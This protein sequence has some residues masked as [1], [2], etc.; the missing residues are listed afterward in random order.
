[1]TSRGKVLGVVL[2]GAVLLGLASNKD[3]L[4]EKLYTL[5]L[6]YGVVTW[7]TLLLLVGCLIGLRRGTGANTVALGYPALNGA[8]GEQAA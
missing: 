2:L 8:A 5:S 4:G 3:P 7:Q 6:W 1:L